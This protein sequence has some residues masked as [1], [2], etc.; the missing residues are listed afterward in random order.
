VHSEVTRESLIAGLEA[1][2]RAGDAKALAECFAPLGMCVTRRVGR[3]RSVRR[4]VSVATGR[5]ELAREF[6]RK[7]L[8]APGSVLSFTAVSYGSDQRIWTEWVISLPGPRAAALA[9]GVSILE[10]EADGIRAATVY[11]H[12]GRKLS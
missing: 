3:R 1:G 5:R 2:W 4:T 12:P 6:E 9:F 11:M 10:V 8:A 7:L